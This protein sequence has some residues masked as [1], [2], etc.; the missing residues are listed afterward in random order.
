MSLQTQPSGDAGERTGNG[1]P[2]FDLTA[3]A[4]AILGATPRTPAA[5]LQELAARAATP[6]AAAAARLVAVPRSR[7]GAEVSF[8]PGAA[9]AAPA[10]LAAL[11]R[12]EHPVTVWLPPAVQAN[13]L[14]HLCAAGRATAADRSALVAVQPAPGDPALAD[15]INADRAVAGVPPLQPAAL[16]IEQ[17][18]LADLHA[19]AIVASCLAGPDAAAELASLVRTAAPGPSAVL[20]RRAAAAWA[21]GS[22][23]GL[24]ALHDDVEALRGQLRERS[25]TGLV[26]EFSRAVRSWAALDAPQRAADARAGLDH[27]PALRA[28]SPWRAAAAALAADGRPDLGL[29]L[30]Q[31]LAEVFGDL[32]GEAAALQ[33]EVRF[34]TGQV[35]DQALEQHLMPLRALA[36]RLGAAPDRLQADLAKRPFGPGARDAAGE[37]WSLF[38]A[39]VQASAVSEAP[40]TI[41][42]ALAQRIGG[43]WR[44]SGAASAVVLQRG[45]IERAGMAGRT[46]LMAVLAA[47]QRGLVEGALTH[48]YETRMQSMKGFWG[49]GLIQRRAALAALRRLLPAVAD[50]VRRAG[51][52]E[53]ERM[54]AKG[55]R[56]NWLAAVGLVSAV[57]ALVRV[58]VL[59]G[60]YARNAPYRQP[61]QRGVPAPA[62]AAPPIRTDGIVADEPPMAKLP[63]PLPPSAKFPDEQPAPAPVPRPAF[64]VR[65]PREVQPLP[66]GGALTLAEATW[67]AFNGTRLDAADAAAT[68]Q[69]LPGVQTLRVT[70]NT[71]C[72]GAR[73]TPRATSASAAT[74]AANEARLPAEGRAMLLGAP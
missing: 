3:N 12:G 53:Q 43:P 50:P 74:A 45:L 9:D 48:D 64:P 10:L 39:A 22:A 13:V 33:A 28:L 51:L 1:P 21:R 46:A 62:P 66:R 16:R 55:S 4:F 60:D 2:R 47:E 26:D 35:D 36:D 20:M 40:W 73:P 56:G 17:D 15:A 54:L 65:L 41:L 7:L 30:A 61:V 18:G 38:N 19:A 72:K 14:A 23:A 42:R 31:T 67:C 52:A 59:D 63:V 68:P 27:E 25:D 71:L 70:W 49:G 5:E 69:Q 24:M 8:L 44:R 29:R 37:L 34:I 11:A 58:A 57:V 6:A 32:P